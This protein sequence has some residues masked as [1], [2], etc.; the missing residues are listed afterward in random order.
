MVFLTFFILY[1][2]SMFES[3][4]VTVKVQVLS[5]YV[6]WT[7]FQGAFLSILV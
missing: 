4:L 3:P 2:H 5:A 1:S 7:A 6:V